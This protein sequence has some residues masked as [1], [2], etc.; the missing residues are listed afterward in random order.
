MR[1]GLVSVPG[2]VVLRTDDQTAALFSS[3]IDCFDNVNQFLL[4]FAVYLSVYAYS[5]LGK[6]C[7]QNPVQLV[8]ITSAKIAYGS[9]VRGMINVS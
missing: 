6:A 4:I 5:V 1:H 9:L 3:A 8:I 7:L 2:R